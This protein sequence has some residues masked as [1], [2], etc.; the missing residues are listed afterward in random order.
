MKT[1]F[2]KSLLVLASAVFGLFCFFALVILVFMNSLYYE[3][4]TRNMR[5]AARLLAPFLNESVFDHTAA[6]RRQS[7]L[8][9][10]GGAYR[11]T[12]T[13]T[14]GTVIYDS[15]FDAK[16]MEN[17][18]GRP[19]F[20]A[21]LAGNEGVA[22]R[23]SSTAGIDNLYFAIPVYTGKPPRIS[24]ALR[25][26][27]PVPSFG[28][29][30]AAAV[31]PNAYLPFLA[32][33]AAVAAVY[34]FS[35]SLGRSFMRLEKLAKTVSS[36]PH[37]EIA[38]L[39]FVSVSDTEEFRA[40]E[41]ALRNMAAELARRIEEAQ[42]EGSRLEGILDGMNEAVFAVDGN[43]VLRL[44]NPSA[45]RLFSIAEGDEPYFLEAVRATELE[46]AARRVLS[47]GGP[48][49]SELHLSLGGTRRFFRVFAGPLKPAG[50][51]IIVLEDVT[52][53]KRLE[54]VRKDF[55]ANVSHEL[56]TP[57][58]LI[59]GYAETLPDLPPDDGETLRRGLA[60]IQKNAIAMENLTADLLSLAAMEA[61]EDSDAPRPE[62]A[63]Q[64]IRPLLDEA[65][66]T[67]ALPA[68][69]KRTTISLACAPGLR[70]TVHGALVVQA[71][72]NL[73]DNA[74]KYTPDGSRIVVRA[75]K[76]GDEGG[77]LF[78]EVADNGPGIAPEHLNR[79][80]ER[81][82][83]VDRTRSRGASGTGL[84][85]AIVRHTALMHGGTAE[86]ESRAGSGSV[87]RIRLPAGPSGRGREGA[88]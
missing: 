43:L 65:A 77:E 49:E 21:A 22:L 37:T 14:D 32:A 88:K 12:L 33:A 81:F 23:K 44:V 1:V 72:V 34:A 63:E 82:Y 41:S 40:L 84:G 76:G 79:I 5:E 20:V 9:A 80:F 54:Q 17:H 2:G 47:G 60:V 85:L 42:A 87:F 52:R 50:G 48:E 86:A 73:L 71:L 78:L 18:G 7:P 62:M 70:A 55:V 25:L 83:R 38:A 61:M 59:K 24:G 26:A 58:Q 28:G 19:E 35:R 6:S 29:R 31:L 45:R 69:E 39:P 13:G 16:N 8:P 46:D 10:T 64:E 53:L 57:I 67:A 30:V 56:R 36:T 15:G 4:N 66:L 11:L 51:V 27:L 75:F 3:T 74:V 68:R